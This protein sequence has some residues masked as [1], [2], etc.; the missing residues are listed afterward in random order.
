[1]S[2]LAQS[3]IQQMREPY[4]CFLQLLPHDRGVRCNIG[5]VDLHLP[6]WLVTGRACRMQYSVRACSAM[7]KDSFAQSIGAEWVQLSILAGV[8]VFISSVAALR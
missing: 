4:T 2:L 1:M 6:R 8:I 7:A 5:R 3:G